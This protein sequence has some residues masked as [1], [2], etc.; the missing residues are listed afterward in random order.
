MPRCLGWDVFDCNFKI[1]EFCNYY[2]GTSDIGLIWFHLLV[3]T[4]IR[5][6]VMWDFCKR[7]CFG[8]NKMQY[9]MDLVSRVLCLLSGQKLS[10]Y[11][12][13]KIEEGLIN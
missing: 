10:K 3:G 2:L 7:Q 5:T 12:E 8:C 11:V 1:E 13:C 9:V 4:V 6:C